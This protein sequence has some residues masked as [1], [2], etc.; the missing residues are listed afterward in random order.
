MQTK[1]QNK[2]VDLSD[3]LDVAKKWDIIMY[4]ANP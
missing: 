4:A 2:C 1:W 3:L